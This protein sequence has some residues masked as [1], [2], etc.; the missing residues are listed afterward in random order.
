MSKFYGKVGFGLSSQV[1]TSPGVWEVV[2]V[3]RNYYGDIIQNNFRNQSNNSTTNDDIVVT[4]RISIVADPYAHN[5]FNEIKYVVWRGT[6]WKVTSVEEQYP[7]L[8]LSLG[9]VYVD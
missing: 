5:N 4:N 2:P 6:K 9:G 3:E 8:I 1:Q 7:R